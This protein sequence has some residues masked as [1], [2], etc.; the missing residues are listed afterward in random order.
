MS[1]TDKNKFLHIITISIT[2]FLA[3]CLDTSVENIPDSF[4]F[5]SQLK[6]VNLA[7]VTNAQS[8]SV[9]NKEGTEVGSFTI[10]LGQE[11]PAEGVPFMDIPSGSKTFVVHFAGSPNDTLRL[12]LE[13]ERRIR[14]Y[15]FN[16]DTV[17]TDI[18]K[19]TLRYTWQEKNSENGRG[20][21]Y[22]DSA[23][24]SFLNGTVDATI[25]SVIAQSI[26]I[27]TLIHFEEALVVG[28]SSSLMLKAP[29]NYTLYFLSDADDT[30]SI[31]TLN[32]NALSRY[33]TV[34]YGS[35]GSGTLT[36][37]VYTDD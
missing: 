37:K 18:L 20:L 29:A 24:V 14:L 31:L 16:P 8:I 15:I 28:G 26:D 10:G 33:T 34:L 4:D 5:H 2:L 32:A 11:F 25:A 6:I 36:S 19:S 27:D 17:T 21:F 13:S 12:S 30:L 3:G 1:K 23:S 9:F 22:P 35:Q 7:S